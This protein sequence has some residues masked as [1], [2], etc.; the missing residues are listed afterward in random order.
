MTN[1]GSSLVSKA[2]S[3]RTLC[4]HYLS[5]TWIGLGEKGSQHVP[6]KIWCVHAL[7][8]TKLARWK[9]SFKCTHLRTR[10]TYVCVHTEYDRGVNTFSPEGRIFQVEYALEAIKVCMHLLSSCSRNKIPEPQASANA[11]LSHAHTHSL[12]PR[13][14]ELSRPKAPSS[15]WRS[16]SLPRC[17]CVCPR[18]CR[19]NFG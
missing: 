3:E 11:C 1:S 10:P 7:G 2:S 17:W 5:I 12:D 8:N 14:L 18:N 15:P 19:P 4:A 6:H 13:P 9:P 16:A